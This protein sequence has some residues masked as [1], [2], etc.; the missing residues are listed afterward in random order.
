M[1]EQLSL[2]IVALLLGCEA[3]TNVMVRDG[4]PYLFPM[5][6][7]EENGLPL[8][9]YA[10]GE[11]KPGTKDLNELSFAICFWFG[12]EKYKEC[13]QLTDA[14]EEYLIDNDYVVQNS[15]IEFEFESKSYMGIINV[16]LI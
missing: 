3:F 8:A 4:K 7:S 6:A 13:C 2:D 14:V 16:S 15:K 11:K 12:M 1:F 9:T 10:L 5:V